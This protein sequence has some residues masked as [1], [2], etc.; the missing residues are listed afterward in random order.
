MPAAPPT[1]APDTQTHNRLSLAPSLL[2]HLVVVCAAVVPLEDVH[3]GAA[4]A[5][6]QVGRTHTLPA[7]NR[8]RA[9]ALHSSKKFSNACDCTNLNKACIVFKPQV[10]RCLL[11][12]CTD[13]VDAMA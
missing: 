3:P 12:T 9:Q 7:G 5:G 4:I 6:Q 2:P 13:G 10:A 1:K 8:G 11:V